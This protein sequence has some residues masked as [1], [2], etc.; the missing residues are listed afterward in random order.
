MM[1]DIQDWM[2]EQR[3]YWEENPA[4]KKIFDKAVI[5][6]MQINK[7][8]ECLNNTSVPNE[9]VHLEIQIS[10]AESKL[11]KLEHELDDSVP[12][13]SQS[14]DEKSLQKQWRSIGGK[15]HHADDRKAFKNDYRAER[16]TTAEVSFPRQK[17]ISELRKHYPHIA[18]TTLTVWAKQADKEDNYIRKPGRPKKG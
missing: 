16:G 14:T 9:V 13:S 8:T 1:D 5:L 17:V 3:I 18:D 6:H 11:K 10:K 4:Q 7:W 2:N 15:S 12:R